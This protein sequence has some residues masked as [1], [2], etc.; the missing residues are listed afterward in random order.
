MGQLVYNSSTWVEMDDRTLA[1]LQIVIGAKLR[2]GEGFPFRWA[3]ESDEGEVNGLWIATGISLRFT[4]DGSDLPQ[5]NLDWIDA[6]T[7]AANSDLGL[8]MVPEPV[9]VLSEE[10]D[11]VEDP[12]PAQSSGD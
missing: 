4:Y 6:L 10:Q 7:A 8:Q 11:E 9:S 1:H 5:I 12:E 3:L 2:R